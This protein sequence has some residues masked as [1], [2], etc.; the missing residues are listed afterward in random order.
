[1]IK[2]KRAHRF[3]PQWLA[4][5]A[6]SRWGVSMIQVPQ[7]VCGKSRNVGTQFPV[8]FLSDIEKR[9]GFFARSSAD[10]I[11]DSGETVWAPFRC[12]RHLCGGGAGLA[13]VLGLEVG[14]RTGCA[15]S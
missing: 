14:N 9:G 1:M 13:G 7:I 6:A 4:L 11:N 12:R 5:R 3:Q 15:L 2:A 8:N 10:S